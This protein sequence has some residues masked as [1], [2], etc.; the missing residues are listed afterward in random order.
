M[1]ISQ[2]ISPNA[3]VITNQPQ[4]SPSAMNNAMDQPSQPPVQFDEIEQS[5]SQPQSPIASPLRLNLSDSTC[6]DGVDGTIPVVEGGD[7]IYFTKRMDS[8]DKKYQMLS[9]LWP[10]DVWYNNRHFNYCENAFQY[11]FAIH[12]GQQFIA[13]QIAMESTTPEHAQALASGI[14]SILPSWHAIKFDKLKDILRS[15]AAQHKDYEALLLDTAGRELK[16]DSANSYWGCKGKKPKG[17]MGLLLMQLREELQMKHYLN[18]QRKVLL[19]VHAASFHPASPTTEPVGDQHSTA[20]TRPAPPVYDDVDQHRTAPSRPQTSTTSPG[21]APTTTPVDPV[22]NH[23]YILG[24][25][26]AHGIHPKLPPEF[27]VHTIPRSGATLGELTNLVP[28]A[29]SSNASHVTIMGGTNDSHL[30]PDTFGQAYDALVKAV[31]SQCPKA[32]I[33]CC[34]LFDRKDKH[35]TG[36]LQELNTRIM[37]TGHQYINNIENPSKMD[38]HTSAGQHLNQTGQVYFSEAVRKCILQPEL[39]VV[40]TFNKAASAQ[41]KPPPRMR[42]KPN[43]QPKPPVPPAWWGKSVPTQHQVRQETPANQPP[44]RHA[45]THRSSRRDTRQSHGEAAPPQRPRRNTRPPRDARQSR[46]EADPPRRYA[47]QSHWEADPPRDNARQSHWETDS[48]RHDARQSHW[49]ADPPRDDAR[50]SHWEADP[51]RRYTRQSHWEADPPR[52]YTRQSHWEADS[53]RHD[54]RQSHWEADPPRRYARQSHW[55]ADSLRHDARQSHWEADPPCHYGRQS[56][57]EANPPRL[58]PGYS[59]WT[60]PPMMPAMLQPNIPVQQYPAYPRYN[61]YPM[62]F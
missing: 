7:P 42:S 23:V 55:E 27:I 30:N 17:K 43:Y 39:E 46:W 35:V 19:N 10:H 25:S 56:H 26:M 18:M 15:T 58:S 51:P 6:Q 44:P 22:Y 37:C 54:A 5:A 21:V 14:K 34:G 9:N 8:G 62:A 52:R 31:Q 57:W 40:H 12:H 24:E 53:P 61:M 59:P 28:H 41:Q 29:L 50:Q 38:I 16:F 3:T 60:M 32:R 11:E 13:D 1:E 49:E 2:D 45:D 47:R 48:P 20:P 36:K 4:Q 33:T